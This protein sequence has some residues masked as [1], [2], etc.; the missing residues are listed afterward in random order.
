MILCTPRRSRLNEGVILRS[1]PNDHN[2]HPL[3]LVTKWFFS[4]WILRYI[5]VVRPFRSTGTELSLR[6]DVLLW[7]L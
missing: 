5:V 2:L 7:K 1:E 3:G 6:L 4:L